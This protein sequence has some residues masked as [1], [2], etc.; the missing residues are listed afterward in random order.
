MARI[1]IT[2]GR[3]I[4]PAQELDRVTSLLIENGKIAAL[5]A[6]PRGGEHVIDAAGKIVAPGLVDLHTQLREPGF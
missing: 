3:V 5:D 4:C 6:Q 2:G 1:L